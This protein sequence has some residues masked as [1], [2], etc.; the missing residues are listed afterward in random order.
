MAKNTK[1][2]IKEERNYSLYLSLTFNTRAILYI[3][4]LK[5]IIVKSKYKGIGNPLSLCVLQLAIA[6]LEIIKSQFIP[7]VD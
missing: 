5:L 1:S 2:K 4:L 3:A 6:E 7:S